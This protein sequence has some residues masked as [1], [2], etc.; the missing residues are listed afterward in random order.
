[1]VRPDRPPQQRTCVACGT[2]ADKRELLRI[3]AP[4]NGPAHLDPTGKSPGRGAYTCRECLASG[5]T[6]GKGRLSYALRRGLTDEEWTALTQQ[7][8]AVNR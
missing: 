2:K 7:M 1:M 3:V 5:R 4:K 8:T 6:A